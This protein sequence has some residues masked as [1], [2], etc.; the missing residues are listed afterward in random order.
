MRRSLGFKLHEAGKPLLDF[1]TF[2]E[3]HRAV[4]IT[5]QLALELG[6][7]TV[8][9]STSGV[10]STTEFRARLCPPSQRHRSANRRFHPMGLLPYRPK[11]ARPYLYTQRG[12]QTACCARL[13]SCPPAVDCGPGPTIVCSGY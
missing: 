1:V 11:R 12:D 3:H 6:S 9:R 13:S 7:T 4:Y 10:G 2:M 5:H 8:D